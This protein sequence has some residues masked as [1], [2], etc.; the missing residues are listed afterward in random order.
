[1]GCIRPRHAGEE[2]GVPELY[3]MKHLIPVL[4]LPLA[5]ACGTPESNS[6]DTAQ[7]TGAKTEPTESPMAEPTETP[8]AQP[9]S[10]ESVY[11]LSATTLGGEAFEMSR[12]QGK[13]VVFVNVASKCGYTP[14]YKELQ[15]LHDEL[16]GDG[17]AI[18][19]VPSNDFGRQEPGTADEIREFCSTNYGVTFDMLAKT[20]TKEG[21]SPLFDRLASMTGERPSWNFCKYV[22]SSDG[23]AAKFFPSSAKPLGD[24]MRGAIDELRG[25]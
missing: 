4:L 5:A 20:G 13:V 16:G 1:M 3:P 10:D 9:V 8:K 23:T 24:E 15:A 14:Q 11:G 25:S 19:G 7:T 21:D 17:F 22:V 2:P 18:V 12:Y 6:N